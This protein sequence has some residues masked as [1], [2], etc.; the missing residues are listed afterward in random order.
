MRLVHHQAVHTQL[1]KG[2]NIV[3]AGLVIEL[4]QFLLQYLLHS[5]HLFDGEI[6]GAF[7]LKSCGLVYHLINLLLQIHLLA[8]KR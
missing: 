3:L 6:L 5:L 2:D 8:L 4:V 1:L 7:C